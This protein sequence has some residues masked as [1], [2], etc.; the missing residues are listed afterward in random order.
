MKRARASGQ[1]HLDVRRHRL[2]KVMRSLLFLLYQ[3]YYDLVQ[4]SSTMCIII[5]GREDTHPWS[6]TKLENPIPATIPVDQ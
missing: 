2:N 4:Q 1:G 5:L 6:S 3:R